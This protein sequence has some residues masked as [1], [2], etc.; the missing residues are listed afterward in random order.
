[1]NLRL[2]IEGFTGCHVQRENTRPW[3]PV[4]F[5][6]EFDPSQLVKAVSSEWVMRNPEPLGAGD[7]GL[8]QSVSPEFGVGAPDPER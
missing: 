2:V 8:R 7:A 6:F 1:M 5:G 4:H 3:H